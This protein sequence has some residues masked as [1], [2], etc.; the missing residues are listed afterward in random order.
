MSIPVQ[1]G[2]KTIVALRYRMKNAQGDLLAD[3]LDE[4]PVCFLY[5]S[6][7]I[8]PGLESMLTG[9]NIGEQKTFTTSPGTTPGL[10]GTYYFDVIIDDI[11]W[12]TDTELNQKVPLVASPDDCGA[13]C[14]C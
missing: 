13:G 11:R 4:D 1:V 10:T 12:A 8:L 7:E 3:I 9:L 5:G 6:G 2:P 14:C